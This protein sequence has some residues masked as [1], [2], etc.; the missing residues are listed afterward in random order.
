MTASLELEP[1]PAAW[2]RS[3]GA[4]ILLLQPGGYFLAV[5]A[6]VATVPPQ[7][8]GDCCLAL[9]VHLADPCKYKIILF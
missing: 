3:T 8:P 7:L 9:T 1:L 6:V 2:T 5:S 4:A